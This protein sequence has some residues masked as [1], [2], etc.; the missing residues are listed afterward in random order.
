MANAKVKA[1]MDMDSKGF[2]RGVDKAEDRISRMKSGLKDMK[3]VIAGAFTVGAVVQLG[4]GIG[5]YAREIQAAAI[6]TGLTAEELQLVALASKESGGGIDELRGAAGSLRGVMSDALAGGQ[7]ARDAFE[8]LGITVEDLVDKN[9]SEL[10]EAVARATQETQDFGA[11]ATILGEDDL[12]RLQAGLIE[13]GEKGFGGLAEEMKGASDIMSADLV[14]SAAEADKFFG[15]LGTKI[16]VFT[17]NSLAN[18]VDIGR[19]A[20]DFAVGLKE[21]GSIQGARRFAGE[22]DF[23]RQK[24]REDARQAEKTAKDE[25]GRKARQAILDK[26]VAKEED[27]EKE[28]AAKTA[29][30]RAERKPQLDTDQLRRIGA[31]ALGSGHIRNR[32]KEKIDIAKKQLDVQEKLLAEAKA[33]A[34]TTTVF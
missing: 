13:L 20:K 27:E 19:A 3:G 31:Q 14:Q 10:L 7:G 8:Q 1:S 33:D 6:Q 2:I 24:A 32:D 4:R 11:A 29:S 21:T 22:R 18:F 9:I 30:T 12:M 17:A 25:Q 34:G 16:K 28:K 23:A 15:R 5:E 26:A